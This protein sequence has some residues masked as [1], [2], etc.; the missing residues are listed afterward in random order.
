MIEKERLKLDKV[1]G[2]IRNMKRLPGALFVV[3]IK[4]EDIAVAEA[5]RLN[6]PIF[7]IVDTNAD[8]DMVNHPIPANDDSFKSIGLITRILTD[9]VLE[10][11]KVLQEAQPIKP[12]KPPE[13]AKK[14]PRRRHRSRSRG[15]GEDRRERK[16]QANKEGAI[17]AQG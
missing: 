12:E 10:G 8:P 11:Q 1:L 17:P 7:A 15:R 2:G 5:R 16:P 4:K 3:D 6:I 9:A 13:Q 14:P